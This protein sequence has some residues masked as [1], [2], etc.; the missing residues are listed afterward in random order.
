MC[1]DVMRVRYLDWSEGGA[2]L[3]LNQ[4]A[5]TWLKAIGLSA[6]TEYDE[7]ACKGEAPY[8]AEIEFGDVLDALTFVR[9]YFPDYTEEEQEERDG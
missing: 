4:R 9:R 5:L 7:E 1:E 6:S 2:H 8:V 3:Q